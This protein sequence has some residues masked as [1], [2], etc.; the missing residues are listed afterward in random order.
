MDILKQLSEAI[1]VS[2]EEGE[3]RG[4]VLD[5]IRDHVDDIQTDTMGNIIA[6]KHGTGPE[7][8]L[9]VMVD[10]HMDEVGMMVTGYDSNGMLKV[11][12]VGGLDARLLPGLRVV[13]GE[14]KLPGVIGV[15][16]IH[17][18]SSSERSK[19]TDID[20]LRVDIGAS[21]KDEAKKKAPLGT[22]IGFHS[23]FEDMGDVVRGKAFDDRAG[24]AMLVTL[25]QGERFPFDLIASFTVQEEVGLRGAKVAAHR[26]KPDMAIALEGTIA[27]DLPKDEDED[28]SPTTEL[29]KGPAIS[30]VDRS[31]IYDKRL[32]ALLTAT[33]E[34][35]GIAYQYKQ[36]GVGGTNAGSIAL[37]ETGVPAAC[38]AVP[39]R[40]I[41]SP[42]A[43][44]NKQD[45]QNA[46]RLVREA[47]M[48][49]DAA[50][51]AR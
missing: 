23:Q 13:V 46:I 16:P 28:L 30:V 49:L 24:C 4:I 41:H 27:D 37:S 5:F 43:Y 47:L 38:V 20:G 15:K 25:L 40:Y 29:G 18:A 14:K 48:R 51:L 3:V 26:A 10:A 45:Y 9:R 33:A 19:T 17:I 31:V 22:R 34:D 36:P 35:L 39:C 7:P 32:N 42:T 1:G 44:L 50:V 2:G 21:G 12:S 8:R 6:T 11:A